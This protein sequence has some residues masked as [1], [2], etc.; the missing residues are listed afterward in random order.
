MVKNKGVQ[1]QRKII[2]VTATLVASCYPVLGTVPQPSIYAEGLGTTNFLRALNSTE[3]LQELPPF[4]LYEAGIPTAE[5]SFCITP[6]MLEKVKQARE[7][8]AGSG[9]S[10]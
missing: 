3:G 8:Y 2:A 9:Y 7:Y 5:V 4:N 10:G 1:I 6:D